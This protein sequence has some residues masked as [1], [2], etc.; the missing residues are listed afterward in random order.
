MGPCWPCQLPQMIFAATPS[1]CIIGIWLLLYYWY[2]G[3]IIL[4]LAFK[5]SQSWKPIESYLS[6]AGIYACIIPF[7]AVI[8]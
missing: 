6:E 1:F 7:P 3:S 2:F 5:L 8:H 4:S